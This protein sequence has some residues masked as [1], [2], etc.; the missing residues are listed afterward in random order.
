MVDEPTSTEDRLEVYQIR[1]TGHL[2]DEWTDWFGGATVTR[3]E[4]GNTLLI[5]RGIDQAALH[6][7]L[8]QIRDL[9]VPLISVNRIGPPVTTHYPSTATT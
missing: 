9:G 4:G 1:I 7:L 3:E 5:C 8:R 2:D 6:G